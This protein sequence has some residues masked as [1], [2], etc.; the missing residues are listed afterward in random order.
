[1]KS[2][3]PTEQYYAERTRCVSSYVSWVSR[4]EG[5]VNRAKRI[6]LREPSALRAQ[7]SRAAQRALKD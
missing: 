2:L 7:T 1:M 4:F 6:A 5:V 3:S